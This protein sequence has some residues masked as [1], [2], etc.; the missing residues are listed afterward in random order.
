M[1]NTYE[2]LMYSTPRGKEAVTNWDSERKEA[3][4]EM[5]KCY[6]ILINKD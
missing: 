3:K 1:R 5:Q 6:D 2:K 4:A